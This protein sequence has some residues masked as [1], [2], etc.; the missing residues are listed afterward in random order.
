VSPVAF[1]DG[2]PPDQIGILVRDLEQA[3]A[4]YEALWG[5]GPWRVYTYG[6]GAIPW[7]TYRGEPGLHRMRIALSAHSPQ[8]ELIESLDGPSIY[9]EHLASCGEGLHHLGFQVESLDAAID[10]MA[11]AGYDVVQSGGGFGLDGDGGYAYFDTDRDLG[12]V[13]EAIEV[14]KRRREPESTYPR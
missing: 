7:V 1:L 5:G 12:V 9:E 10:S 11:Q 6:H 4:R 13:L 14:P 3:L 2:R 8:V